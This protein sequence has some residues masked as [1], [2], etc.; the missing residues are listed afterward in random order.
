MSVLTAQPH[1]PT[2]REVGSSEP[3]S[4]RRV[5]VSAYAI[6]PARGSESG[7][8]WNICRRLAD[9]HDVTVL[10]A[11]GMPGREHAC[12]REE[13]DRYVGDHGP[14]RG[15]TVHYVDRPAWSN[16]WQRER[17]L[18][19][20]TLY[21]SGY[22][23]WQRAAYRLGRQLHSARP[24]DL[25]HQLNMTGFREPGYLWKLDAPF[26]WGPIGGAADVPPAF[27]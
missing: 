18:F 16:L 19:R 1:C 7:M 22:K 12:Y 11:E 5:L 8:G 25:V 3:S 24:F 6:S 10:C 9:Y 4:R 13:V 27:F 21:Y 2:P 26:V 20:R 17:E 14:V 23:A 15:L